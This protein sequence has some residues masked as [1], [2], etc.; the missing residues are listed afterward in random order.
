L[1]VD[2][3]RQ[4]NTLNVVERPQREE[5]TRLDRPQA[6]LPKDFPA[7]RIMPSEGHTGII[8]DGHHGFPPDLPD[9]RQAG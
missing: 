9:T 4:W 6:Y 1:R 5:K 3:H 7:D 2:G 8:Q